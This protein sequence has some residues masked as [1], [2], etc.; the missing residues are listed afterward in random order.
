MRKQY[1]DS[2]G[3]EIHA[4]FCRLM[5]SATRLK[6]IWLLKDRERSVTELSEALELP[7]PN[8]SQHLR[9]MRD[10]G[11]VTTRKQGQTVYYMISNEKF[12]KGLTLIREGINELYRK[13]VEDISS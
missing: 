8:V 9:V 3:F 2:K 7:A 6:I 12:V 1:I 13:N 11:A 5:S 10:K 4:D